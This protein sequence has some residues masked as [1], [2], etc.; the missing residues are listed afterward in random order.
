LLKQGKKRENEKSSF[1]GVK[2]L[3]EGIKKGFFTG[4][5]ICEGNR[6][7]RSQRKKNRAH[8]PPERDWGGILFDVNMYFPWGCAPRKK[9]ASK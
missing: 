7:G 5:P 2:I 1:D 9:K 6:I 4:G 3:E 8:F